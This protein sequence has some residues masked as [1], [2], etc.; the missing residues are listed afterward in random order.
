MTTRHPHPTGTNPRDVPQL[1]HRERGEGKWRYGYSDIARATGLKRSTVMSYAARGK[2]D[3]TDLASVA[4]FI[5]ARESHGSAPSR[6]N[7][8]RRVKGVFY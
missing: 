3:P 7:R 8:R 6:D 5:A 1:H 4:R 2:F